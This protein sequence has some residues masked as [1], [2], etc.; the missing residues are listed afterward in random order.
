MESFPLVKFARK[1]FGSSTPLSPLIRTFRTPSKCTNPKSFA[2]PVTCARNFFMTTRCNA[3]WSFRNSVRMIESSRTTTGKIFFACSSM[4]S[5]SS[6]VT[7]ANLQSVSTSAGLNLS[8]VGISSSRI[9]LRV[10]SS[11]KFVASTRG[12]KFL[13]RQNSSSSTFLN[14]SNGRISKP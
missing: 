14:L 9:R 13:F 7:S 11:S 5:D 10:A 12:D 2:E 6:A 4:K 3:G 1:F 8:S